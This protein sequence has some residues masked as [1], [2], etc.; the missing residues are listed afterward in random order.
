[1][2]GGSKMKNKQMKE[3]YEQIP[4]NLKPDFLEIVKDYRERDRPMFYRFIV[5]EMLLLILFGL[6][7]LTGW[8][9]VWILLMAVVY[10][11]Y[12]H[13]DNK[14][15]NTFQ[16]KWEKVLNIPP[17]LDFLHMEEMHERWLKRKQ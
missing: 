13:F 14:M 1:M 15:A 3:A 16:D 7:I 9:I 17:Y 10:F 4:E 2:M 8:A 11:I 12:I 6:T 5:I